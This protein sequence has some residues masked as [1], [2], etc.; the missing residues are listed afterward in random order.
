MNIPE[1]LSETF[2]FVYFHNQNLRKSHPNG[3]NTFQKSHDTPH[4]QTW[5]PEDGAFLTEV[6]GSPEYWAPEVA[7]CEYTLAADVWVGSL[8]PQFFHSIPQLNSN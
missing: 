3:P 2:I 5:P 1:T 7:A 6:F 8:T 4:L